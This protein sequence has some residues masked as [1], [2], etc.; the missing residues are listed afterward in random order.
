MLTPCLGLCPY[1]R[2]AVGCSVS[3]NIRVVYWSHLRLACCP[4]ACR[5][6]GALEGWV[7]PLGHPGQRWSPAVS[8]ARGQPAPGLLHP[9]GAL[10]ERVR[11]LR[12]LTG[13][14]NERVFKVTSLG[15]LHWLLHAA[16][17]K[18]QVTRKIHMEA[19]VFVCLVTFVSSHTR[20]FCQLLP[21][22]WQKARW[23]TV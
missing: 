22:V 13:A 15:G 5:G 19:L 23:S 1:A 18:L 12:S 4:G 8:A 21:K 16:N 20:L 3:P 7:R 14:Q 17:P 6:T 11:P 2:N 9:P 10:R